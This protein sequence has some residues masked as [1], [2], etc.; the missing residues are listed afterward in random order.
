MHPLLPV[1][2]IRDWDSYTIKNEPINS[3][4]LMERASLAFSNWFI[5]NNSEEYPKILV[6]ASKGNNGG[7]G[8]A[9][10]RILHEKVFDIDILIADIQPK[11]SRDFAINHKRLE[12]KRIESRFLV[13]DDDFPDFNQFD[14][15]IDALFGSG[16]SRPISGYWEELVEK[17]NKSNAKIYSVD[18][19]SGMYSNKPNDGITIEADFCFT[20]EVPKLGMLLADN[21]K[22]IKNWSFKSIG[23]KPDYLSTISL[24]TFYT[25]RT[26]IIK[27][28]K[29][30]NKFDHK[31][32]YGHSL[33]VGGQKGMIGAAVL[34]AKSCLK[35]GSGLVT[36]LIPDT[37]NDIVQISIPE[38]MT[39]SG[40]GD[41]YLTAVPAI[42]KYSS[43]GVGIGMGKNKKTKLFLEE[44]LKTVKAP[45]VIDADA[46][47]IIS[48]NKEL[49]NI[50][51]KI[52]I[53]TPHPGEFARLFGPTINGFERIKLLRKSAKNLKVYIILKGAYTAIASPTGIV[54]FNS[55]G[56]PGMATAGSGD[57]LTGI[58]TSL[59]GQGYTSLD[60][61]LIGT[62][63]HG[64][65]GDIAAEKHNKN[66][67]IASDIIDNIGEAYNHSS[68]TQSI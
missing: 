11:E 21:S 35:T 61:C 18:I 57:V 33:I 64:L 5:L 40:Y 36:A 26:D 67:I 28:L 66:N 27:L 37:G 3:I 19:P 2:E 43:I 16:I 30:R 42:N 8:L 44:L 32:K 12:E 47:N 24:D 1:N 41:K 65:A 29:P 59:L 23:L 53:L 14:I 50:I 49:L 68:I 56:N 60:S 58:I 22:I 62:F 45:I 6:I 39:I 17:I 51:P 48:E 25:D 20:F 13:K 15:I 10:A 52:S 55:T 9:I 38:V 31:G 46:L 54:Y 7:D 4:D 34:A 63:L